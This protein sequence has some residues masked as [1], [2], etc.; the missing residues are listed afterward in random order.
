MLTSIGSLSVQLSGPLG[1]S[2][3][4]LPSL[5]EVCA[6]GWHDILY[7]LLCL[8]DTLPLYFVN[9]AFIKFSSNYPNLYVPSVSGWAMNDK[10]PQKWQMSSPETFILRAYS[11]TVLQE[12]SYASS[13][14]SPTV[15]F[16]GLLKADTL[17]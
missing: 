4:S 6:W 7:Y 9:Y 11:R 14:L 8:L 16:L 10:H 13:L 5:L 15:G 2:N 1:I 3:C 12:T 17:Q